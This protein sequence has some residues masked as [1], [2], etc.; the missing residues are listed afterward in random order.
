MADRNFNR[1]QSATK[2]AKL[3]HAHVTIGAS[4]APTLNA[5][6]SQGV[7]SVSRTSAG[8]YVMT[9]SDRYNSLLDMHAMVLNSSI[10]DIQVQIKSEDVAVAKT[11]TFNTK[12]PTNSSTTTQVVTDPANGTV[13]KISVWVKNSDIL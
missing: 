8:L 2:E 4:G 5:S 10:N 6:K 12:A 3:V 7:A 1:I 9:L 11:I 13:L